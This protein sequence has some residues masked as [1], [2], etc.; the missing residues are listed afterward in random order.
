MCIHR[1]HSSAAKPLFFS[2][3]CIHPLDLLK[4][5]EMLPSP[6]HFIFSL[7]R[8]FLLLRSRIFERDIMMA[9]KSMATRAP[10]RTSGVF[11]LPVLTPMPADSS[12]AIIGATWALHSS[13]SFLNDGIVNKQA[14]GCAKW[15][16]RDWKTPPGGSQIQHRTREVQRR[17]VANEIGQLLERHSVCRSAACRVKRATPARSRLLPASHLLGFCA[18]STRSGSYSLPFGH[19]QRLSF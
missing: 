1:F 5:S 12:S 4:Q 13:S 15:F 2:Y 14:G 6:P 7:L 8:L 10:E 17:A 11:G 9:Q 16:R 3:F 19:T 18:V